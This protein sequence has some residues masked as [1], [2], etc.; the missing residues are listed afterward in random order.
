MEIYFNIAVFGGAALMVTNIVRY[1]LFARALASLGGRKRAFR[2]LLDLPN[3]LLLS[4]LIGYILV[5]S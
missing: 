3:V 5:A 1:F 2:V 4:F